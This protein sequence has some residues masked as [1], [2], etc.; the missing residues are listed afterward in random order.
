ML[1]SGLR[2][3]VLARRALAVRVPRMSPGETLWVAML[4]VW[5][6]WLLTSCEMADD[7]PRRV[8]GGE[9]RLKAG[10]RPRGTSN[11]ERGPL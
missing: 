3:G 5:N 11:A 4:L 2:F 8:S 1:P 6:L 7:R 9:R 10:A